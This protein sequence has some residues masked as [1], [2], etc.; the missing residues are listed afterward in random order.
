MDHTIENIIHYEHK[1]TDKVAKLIP[2]GNIIG[3]HLQSWVPIL[4][5]QYLGVEIEVERCADAYLLQDAG[6]VE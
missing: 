2:T 3:E 5:D 4:P 1:L 6:R